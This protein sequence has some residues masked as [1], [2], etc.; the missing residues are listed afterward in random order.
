MKKIQHTCE[1][2][3][4]EFAIEYD[5]LEAEDGPCMCPFC[6]GYMIMDLDENDDE[7]VDL[8]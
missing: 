7:F 1:E 2:C 4:T 3:E 6:G 8:Q 5:E